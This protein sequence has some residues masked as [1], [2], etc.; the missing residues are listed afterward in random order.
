MRYEMSRDGSNHGEDLADTMHAA[1]ENEQGM[2]EGSADLD[3]MAADAT[4]R[5]K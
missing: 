2:Y 3:V 1:C 5:A 4:L